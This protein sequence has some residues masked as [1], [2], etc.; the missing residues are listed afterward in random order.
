MSDSDD[1]DD[2]SEDSSSR[3]AIRAAPTVT[4]KERQEDLKTYHANNALFETIKTKLKNRIEPYLNPSNIRE[5]DTDVLFDDLDCFD[6]HCDI[7]INNV[8]SLQKKI[9][10]ELRKHTKELRKEKALEKKKR[11]LEKKAAKENKPSRSSSFNASI[12]KFKKIVLGLDNENLSCPICLEGYV[13]NETRLARFDECG[14][15][16]CHSCLLKYN[17]NNMDYC[18]LCRSSVKKQKN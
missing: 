9:G 16:M 12:F 13:L 6:R 1:S 2:D 18:S 3:F 8:K 7:I 5:M 4:E 17:T 15:I 10:Y 11:A 14:H